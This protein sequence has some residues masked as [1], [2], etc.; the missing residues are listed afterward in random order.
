MERT[1]RK[2][3]SA[4]A[5]KLYWGAAF[6]PAEG[7]PS[8]ISN[9]PSAPRS[10]PSSRNVVLPP[11]LGLVCRSAQHARMACRDLRRIAFRDLAST[12]L[13]QLMWASSGV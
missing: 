12:S 13:L 8:A 3:I 4:R 10:W 6:P 9:T 7:A 11:K 1:L 2:G 5:I